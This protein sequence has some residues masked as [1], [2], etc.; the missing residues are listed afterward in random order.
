MPIT[1]DLDVLVRE[2]RL[3]RGLEGPQLILTWK[4]P[5][6]TTDIEAI[7][8]VRK[9]YEFPATVGDGLIVFD[10]PPADGFVTDL[11]LAPCT[12]YYYT[13][14]TKTFGG[15]YLHHVTTQAAELAIET[16]FFAKKLFNMLPDMYVIGDKR[17]EEGGVGRLTLTKIFDSLSSEFFNL[18]EA[19]EK[20]R[21]ELERFLRVVAVELDIVKGLI[22]CLPSQFDVD[23]TCCKNLQAM[24]ALLDLQLNTEFP[25][26]KQRNEIKSQVPILQKK[27]TKASIEARARA[28][29]GLPT[30]I[31]EWCG[32]ILITNRLSRTTVR[33]D[34]GSQNYGLPGDTTDYTP[35]GEKTFT[36]FT[37]FFMLECDDCLDK[38]VVL[39]LERELPRL[40]PVCRTGHLVFVDC[41]F[42]EEYDV[43]DIE[44]FAT[45]EIEDAVVVEDVRTHCWL[46]TNRLTD[47][48]SPAPL[49]PS[50][51]L[52]QERHYTNSLAAMTANPFRVC[53]ERWWDEIECCGRI[54]QAR[55]NCSR[56]NVD[57]E[58]TLCIDRVDAGRVDCSRVP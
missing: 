49:G 28:I 2:L 32:N 31:Q 27:G 23:D 17:L 37:V 1:V 11:D 6:D 56:I 18:I 35:G 38:P 52:G 26:I 13:V 5:A 42:V 22:D 55:I 40:Y 34:V 36:S 4:V 3:R 16:G 53:V 47:A 54:N 30:R 44:E 15:D 43:E 46:I 25:C 51:F 20:S 33:L 24:A 29:S 8:V 12:C 41:R 19:G 21:G 45:D 39:K 7:V 58:T 14:F 50:L 48:T 10:G 9:K 57:C